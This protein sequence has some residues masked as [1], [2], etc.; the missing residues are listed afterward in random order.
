MAKLMA[1]MPINGKKQA[2]GSQEYGTPMHSAFSACLLPKSRSYICKEQWNLQLKTCSLAVS[3]WPGD[4]PQ[5]VIQEQ[6]ACTS[7]NDG[8]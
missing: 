7:L 6:L 8:S 2:P 1:K 5:E 4:L 3:E